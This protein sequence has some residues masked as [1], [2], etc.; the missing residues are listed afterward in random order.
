MTQR[1]YA[2]DGGRS[3]RKWGDPLMYGKVGPDYS[4]RGR[5]LLFWL[6]CIDAGALVGALVR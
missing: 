3:W 6:V 1:R 4:R 2:Q 5:I